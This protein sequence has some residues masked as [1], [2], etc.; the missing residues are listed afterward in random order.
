MVDRLKEQ[1]QECRINEKRFTD[2]VQL[3]PQGIFEADIAG[4]ITYANQAAV[5]LFGYVQEDIE[6][7][8]NIL[9]CTLP[10]RRSAGERDLHGRDAGREN[11]R[12]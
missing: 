8:L 9:D 10:R 5:S 6:K 7:G 1:I 12:I 11:R 2:L 4:N 3:L